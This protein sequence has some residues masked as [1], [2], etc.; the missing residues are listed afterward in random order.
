M[1]LLKYIKNRV[2]YS[3]RANSDSYIKYLKNKGMSIGI[4]TYFISAK[5]TWIDDQKPWMITIGDNCVIT[6]GVVVLSHDYSWIVLKNKYGDILGNIKETRIGNNCFVGMNSI[7]LCGTQIGNN[8]IIGSNS[9]VSGEYPDDCVIAGNPAKI[10]CT[11]DEFRKKRKE[12]FVNESIK[13]AQLYYLNYK[14]D[15]PKRYL[16][17]HFYVFENRIDNL[18]NVFKNELGDICDNNIVIN[19]FKNNNPY[20]K[21]YENFIE[22]CRIT[23]YTK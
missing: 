21:N 15:I 18:D 3:F 12:K 14:M 7:I 2:I 8:V 20:F 10:I 4:G 1:K 13:F 22:K 16:K 5:D 23:D 9:V 19:N 6:S 11:L 17:E